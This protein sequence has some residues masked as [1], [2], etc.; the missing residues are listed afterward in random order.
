MSTSCVPEGTLNEYLLPG[1]YLMELTCYR[2]ITHRDLNHLFVAQTKLD[3]Q[4]R[5]FA[6]K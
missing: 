5:L 6:N 4:P 2:L 1:R 3:Q